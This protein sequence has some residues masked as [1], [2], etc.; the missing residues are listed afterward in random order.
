MIPKTINQVLKEANESIYLSEQDNYEELEQM[1]RAAEE[2]INRMA[3]NQNPTWLDTMRNKEMRRL[4]QDVLNQADA[5]VPLQAPDF[6]LDMN[7]GLG[8]PLPM[9]IGMNI[10]LDVPEDEPEETDVFYGFGTRRTDPRFDFSSR[11]QS[12]FFEPNQNKLLGF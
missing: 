4:V 1:L 3:N 10:N 8:Q 11:L 5:K 12:P 6:N 2:K 9:D 7:T